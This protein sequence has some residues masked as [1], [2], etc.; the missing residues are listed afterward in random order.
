MQLLPK[1]NEFVFDIKT[2]V[3]AYIGGFGSGK[4][5]GGAIKAL[6]LSGYNERCA[7]MLVSPTYSMLRD[8]TRRTFLELLE[9]NNIG[10]TFRATENRIIINETNSEVWFR[11]ADDPNKLKGSNLAWVG[12]D[13]PGLMEREAYLI[14]L[15][16]IRD[17]KAKARQVFLTGTP[18]GFNWLYDELE[19]KDNNEVKIIKTSSRENNYLPETYINTLLSSYDE[20]LVKQYVD[21]EFVLLNRG[22]VYY[23]FDRNVNLTDKEYNESFPIFLCVD[24]N[25]NPMA[26]AVVQSYNNKVYVVDEIYMQNTNTEKTSELFRSKYPGAEV[27]IYGDYAGKQRHTSSSMT[28]YDIMQK[29]IRPADIRLKPNPSVIDR[30]NAVNGMLKNASGETKLFVNHKCKNLI[31]DFEQVIYKE[32]KR[33]IDKSNLTLTHISDAVGYYIEYEFPIRD[34]MKVTHKFGNY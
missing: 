22:Q 19:N 31:K 24:F 30:V 5:L 29:I 17:P 16:R 28:D 7:G 9:T 32:G 23:A 15:S 2:P 27:V 21:G 1:Q 33:E 6:V 11:S 14:S 26:W 4:T 8:T 34:K 3:I 13:E 12:L 18:E 10:F 20:Q 25:I